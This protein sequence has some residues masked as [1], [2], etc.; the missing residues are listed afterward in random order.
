MKQ[1]V[2]RRLADVAAF[3]NPRAALE[4]YAT[5]ADIAAQLLHLA[6]MQGDLSRPVLDLGTGTGMLA[7]AAALYDAPRVVGVDRDAGPLRTARENERRVAPG[8]GVEWVRGD[9]ASLPVAPP[10]A[11]TVVSNPPF[12]AQQRGA[13]RPFLAAAAEHAAVSYTIHNAGSED[14]VEFFAG[15]RGGEVTHAYRLAFP[16][17]NQFDFHDAEAAQ[18]DAELFRIRWPAARDGE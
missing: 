9:V 16:L 2:E 7:L 1:A 14:F 11:V 17:P 5:P 6:G 8:R 13:D 18:V 3:E 10:E 15:E 12:G 4:Q